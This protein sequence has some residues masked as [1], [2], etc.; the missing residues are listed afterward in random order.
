[1]I[2]HKVGVGGLKEEW[3]QYYKPVRYAL[4]RLISS[5]LDVD[6]NPKNFVFNPEMW[7]LCYVDSKCGAM[8]PAYSNNLNL[9]LLKRDFEITDNKP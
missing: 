4:D 6:W 3:R 7:H 1:M 5:K 9:P 2:N 8:I